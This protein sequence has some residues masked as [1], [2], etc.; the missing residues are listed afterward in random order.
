MSVRTKRGRDLNHLTSPL[1]SWTLVPITSSGTVRMPH[2]W[3]DAPPYMEQL[4]AGHL[5]ARK[6]R[7]S[8]IVRGGTGKCARLMNYHIPDLMLKVGVQSVG[9]RTKNPDEWSIAC[10]LKCRD[11]EYSS[12][13]D[14]ALPQAP[15][16]LRATLFS[17]RYL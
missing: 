10:S 5:D 12:L 16:S 4:V 17:P 15:H 8:T 13:H 6:S 2:L 7:E 3:L 14:I 11:R 1:L 9:A